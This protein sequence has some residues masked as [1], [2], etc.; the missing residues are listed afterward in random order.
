MRKTWVIFI[1]V[2]AI[3]L[4]MVGRPLGALSPDQAVLASGVIDQ[5]VA[6][7][8]AE[9]AARL[10][11]PAKWDPARVARNRQGLGGGLAVLMNEFGR[12]SSPNLSDWAKYYEIEIAGGNNAYWQSLPN[13]GMDSTLTYR[14]H[15]AK[16]GPGIVVLG[17]TRASGVLELATVALGL[18]TSSPHARETI[19]RIGRKF[20]R[21]MIP[22]LD[23]DELEKALSSM[24]AASEAA[25]EAAQPGVEPDG[26]SRGRGLTP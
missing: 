2:I 20:L 16:A 5:L 4:S 6:G 18:E 24:L 14:V 8:A 1:A 9:V 21:F 26:R 7:K 17:F 3:Q 13:G 19:S 10:H 15:F 25:W 12:I 23:H 22:S 11:Q